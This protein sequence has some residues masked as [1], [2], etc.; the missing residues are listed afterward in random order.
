MDV[1]TVLYWLALCATS[2]AIVIHVDNTNGHDS[3]SCHSKSEQPCKTLDYAFINGLKSSNTTIMIHKGIYSMNLLNSSFYNFENVAIYGDG[4]NSTKIKCSFGMGLGFFNMKKLVLANFTLLGGGTIRYSTS[5]NTTS[6]DIAVFRVALYLLNCSD[7]TIDGLVVTNSTGTGLVM[8]NV[9]GNVDIINSIFQFN[10]PLETEELPGDGGVSITFT[11]CKPG[12]TIL[13]NLPV[14]TNVSYNIQNCAFLS[15]IAT[16]AD[17]IKPVEPSHSATIRHNF[18]HGGGMKILMRSEVQNNAI[19][20]KD[21]NFLHNQAVWGGGLFIE[22]LN[23]SRSNHFALENLLFDAN[24]LSQQGFLKTTGSGGGAVRIVVIIPTNSLNYNTTF[25]FTNCLFQNNIADLGGGVSFELTR[26]KPSTTT[27]FCFTNCTW[28]HNIGRLGSAI[29][30]FVHTYPLGDVARFTFD[31]C[32]FVENSNDYSH[33]SMTPFLGLGTMY[34]WSV[35]VYFT[36]KNVFIGNKGSALVGISTWCVFINGAAVVFENNTAE[37]GGAITLLDN[38]YL[39]LYE[40][41]KLNFTYN[42]AAGKGGAIYTD[43]DGQRSFTS[44]RFCFVIFHNAIVSP[45]DWKEKNI[46]IYFANNRAK[47]GD[48]IFS[49]TLLTCIWGEL[50]N[51]EVADIK[52]VYYWNGTFMYEGINNISDLQKEISSEATHIENLKNTSYIFPPGKL[53][54]FNFTAKNDRNETVNAVYSV[55]TNS[56]VAVVDDAFSYT[57]ESDTMLYGEPGSEIQLK[58]VTVNSLPLSIS[59]NVTLDDCPPGFYPSTEIYSN[60]TICRCSVNVEGQ[61]YLGIVKCDTRNMVAYLR[62]AYYAGYVTIAGKKTLLTA[63]CPE[64]YCYSNNSYLELPSNSSSEALDDL[65]CKPNHRTGPLCGKCLAGCYIYVN[66]YNYECGKCTNSWVEGAF[67]LIGYKYIPLAIFLYIVGLFGVSLVNGPLNSAVLF[68]QLLPYMNIYAGGRINTFDK[69]SVT[70]FKFLYGMWNLDF[71]ELVAPN[72]CV[73]P[74]QSAL[75][76][77]LFKNLTP[78]LIGFI[79][80]C[81]YYLISE[82]RNITTSWK[83]SPSPVKKCISYVLCKCCQCSCELKYTRTV[84]W[85]NRKV[86]GNKNEPTT[87]FRSQSLITCTVLCYAKLTSLAFDLLSNTTL[88]GRGKDDSDEFLQVFWLDGTQTYLKDTS[89]ALLLVAAICI[90]IVILIPSV[91]ILY[92]IIAYSYNNERRTVPEYIRL[93]Y[94]SLRLCYKNNHIACSFTA[95]YFCYRIG[96]LAIYAFTTTVHYQYLWQCGFFL[97]MLLIH[98][99]VQPYRK[100]IF[101]VIDGFIFSN[102]TLISLLSLYQ[103]YSVDVGLSE[104]KKAF[105]FQLTLIYLPFVYIVL[106]WPCV[107]FYTYI[108]TKELDSNGNVAKLIKFV[109][110]NLLKEDGKQENEEVAQENDEDQAEM[111]NVPVNSSHSLAVSGNDL[112][113]PL[114]KN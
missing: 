43:T 58:M 46:T 103:L 65:I 31:S 11:H 7:V 89:W 47:H 70:G 66:S 59:I 38:S 104:T 24:Y 82:R 75:V 96:A 23:D 109:D 77:L 90:G 27:H 14:I 5:I 51:I 56:S 42:E 105:T 36:N 74:I 111:Q 12:K 40:N 62:P 30:A 6:R 100:K 79:L 32:S 69:N 95:V 60:K 16:S 91:I 29:D 85:L 107:R 3:Q 53:Y 97:S 1:T 49:T 13:C 80:S 28:Y 93:F 10:V 55:T 41:T 94:D 108:K 37:N 114:L 21:C 113:T 8:Y 50:A 68:S 112:T 61:D 106:L 63:G 34:L 78:V 92:P 110:D 44:D 99:V 15:N 26:E 86:C 20:I 57:S 2:V 25:N 102:M 33:H 67:M 18:G 73:L 98:C 4:S 52:Q 81:L 72:F 35:P 76:M 9:K 48:S 83:N 17:N 84:E 39:V 19:I 22:L 64:G 88:Y 54:Y 101:N 71:F 45:Y 87:C